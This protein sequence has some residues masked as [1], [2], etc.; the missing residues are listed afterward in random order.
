MIKTSLR[1]NG[2]RCSHGE[3]EQD[4]GRKHDGAGSS[5]DWT[6]LKDAGS[7]WSGQ[8]RTERV[9]GGLEKKEARRSKDTAE[10][11]PLKV[12]RTQH[13]VQHINVFF[14]CDGYECKHTQIKTMQRLYHDVHD[15]DG[16]CVWHDCIQCWSAKTKY[17][18]RDPR[19][20]FPVRNMSF[21][22]WYIKQDDA[23]KQITMKTEYLSGASSCKRHQ[24]QAWRDKFTGKDAGHQGAHTRGEQIGKI[25]GTHPERKR[26]RTFARTMV[27]NL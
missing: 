16:N 8:E 7:K 10:A 5:R 26:Q 3:R 22:Y 4:S 24:N 12:S 17:S 2:Q 21:K 20:F 15:Q 14:W 25:H 23:E 18:I 19:Q 27:E 11:A 1:T 9:Q 6:S 13:I